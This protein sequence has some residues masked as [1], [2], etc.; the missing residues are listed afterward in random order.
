MLSVVRNGLFS[1]A[2]KYMKNN[3]N[4]YSVN[5]YDYDLPQKFIA[6]V[7]VKT[8]D[9]SRLLRLLKDSNQIQHHKFADLPKLLLPTDLLVLNNTR[10]VPV[11]L[12]GK[13][14]TG[15]KI[16]ALI[17][18]YGPVAAA[19]PGEKFR[20]EC[21]VKASKKP[22]A[23]TRIDFDAQLW[24]T[25]IEPRDQI[26][27]L[28]FSCTHDPCLVL[29]EIGK[30]PLPPYIHRRN[31]NE[32][33]CDDKKRYQTTYAKTNGAVAAP[34][35][36]LHFTPKLLSEIKKTGVQT[37]HITLHVGYGTF[38][39]IRATDMRKHNMHSEF[40]QIS[41][42]AANTI[43]KAKQDG[44][45]IVAVGTTTV[46]TL[47]YAANNNG[48]IIAKKGLCD[49]FIC[50]GYKFKAIDALITNFHLPKSTL[51]MLVSALA[52]KQTILE[53]YKEAVKQKYRFFS[54]GDAMLIE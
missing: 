21:L 9:Q 19:R 45:R 34:T 14:Q 50:P 35:A 46:R 7:P 33:F 17:L 49:L 15:G 12:T 42:N 4:I 23:G 44:R 13:K 52:G 54:Y 43:N 39:P 32:P 8:R 31:G 51:L 47:E 37:V 30:I 36:G 2:V 48:E 16:E 25:V 28:E 38:M 10:V 1:T 22:K 6:Q 5:A 29:D 53:T 27:V 24:A 20:C 11:R 40:F 18:D 3:D 26:C 41:K